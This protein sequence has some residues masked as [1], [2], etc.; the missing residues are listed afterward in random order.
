[1]KTNYSL[2]V[3]NRVK[4]NKIINEYNK[5][6]KYEILAD[7]EDKNSSDIES[8]IEQYKELFVE[9]IKQDLSFYLTLSLT[10]KNKIKISFKS[11]LLKIIDEE[12]FISDF[13]DDNSLIN[14]FKE[15]ISN[16]MD[17]L[18]ENNN[19]EQFNE[20]FKNDDIL[21][22]NGVPYI[23]QNN[24]KKD[25]A[26]KDKTTSLPKNQI[27]EF[28]EFLKKLQ[29]NESD[30][31]EKVE[32]LCKYTQVPLLADDVKDNLKLYLKLINIKL[33]YK[34]FMSV[35][36]KS[37]DDTLLN[38]LAYLIVENEGKEE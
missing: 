33:Y 29:K 3:I 6:Y 27:N 10:D 8:N 30:K 17:I 31:K 32:T 2:Y 26:K 24:N 16:F 34:F 25:E 37:F 21:T 4:Y 35:V 38:S 14:D 23:Y 28:N 19:D 36:L 13:L 12:S 22:V 18:Y 15:I 1:M 7:S 5:S 9:K 11:E 20:I